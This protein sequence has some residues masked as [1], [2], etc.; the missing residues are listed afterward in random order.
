[1]N[2]LQYLDFV[3]DCGCVNDD[4]YCKCRT[5]K[6]KINGETCTHCFT[7]IDGERAMDICEE[8]K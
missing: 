4:V 3:S 6:N 8:F 5:C 2:D 7:C 1:M